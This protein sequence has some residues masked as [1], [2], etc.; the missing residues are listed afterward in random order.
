MKKISILHTG[1]TIASKV[2][3]K[4][5]GV[6]A[7]FSEKDLLEL[8]PEI[9]SI[10]KISSRLIR[11]MLS[12]DMN[13][14]HYNLL[15]KEIQKEVKKGIEG[16]I[17]THGTDTLHYTS[18]ALSF[19]LENLPIPVIL[20]GAQRSSDR[21]SSDATLNLISALN[22]IDKTDFIGVAICMHE[23]I[24]D[25]SCL[26]LPAT[27]TRKLH[28]SRRDAFKAINSK[29]IAKVSKDKVESIDYIHKKPEGKFEI[30]LF[31]PKIKIGIIKT[32]PNMLS[33]EFKNYSKFH[34]LIIEGTGL[35]HLP[36]NKIDSFTQ[37]NQKI[38][39]EIKKLA[40]KIPII[41]TSQCIFGRINM[42]VYSTGRKLQEVG[43]LG[44]L[45]DMTTETAFIKLVW[46]LSNFKKEQ[47]HKLITET[48][49]GE[50]SN[51]TTTDFL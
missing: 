30:K 20:V 7:K 10:A 14:N 50:I 19:I 5:G 47:I 28:S 42:N 26:I 48:I 8:Y 18:A 38:L 13:F 17:I 40:K 11:N 22:F 41:M 39:N 45:H 37:E 49:R 21:A 31:N 9:K 36:I 16:I 51:R 4:T 27:K 43:V 3:Y 32:H 23:S 24:N 46:L 34:G 2:D 1:G 35:G 15:A 25:N 12:E 33:E 29:P 44:N 6:S